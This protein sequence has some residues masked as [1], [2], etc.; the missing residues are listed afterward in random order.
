MHGGRACRRHAS[1]FQEKAP[2]CSDAPRCRA[3]L[4]PACAQRESPD[5][6]SCSSRAGDR[7]TRLHVVHRLGTSTTPGDRSDPVH[8]QWGLGRG[9][10]IA[11]E[12]SH[13]ATEPTPSLSRGKSSRSWSVQHVS[14]R[15]S[16]FLYLIHPTGR[17]AMPCM[18]ASAARF[19]TS[20]RDP[21]ESTG[22]SQVPHRPSP[23][24]PPTYPLVRRT[25]LPDQ[26]APW[27]Q[28]SAASTPFLRVFAPSIETPS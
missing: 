23:H 20:D 3:R 1:A 17:A 6:Q 10:S 19:R 18:Q 11:I 21:R 26:N 14:E 15:P 9:R 8:Q 27:V 16:N 12:A 22:A 28:P 7:S 24:H 4:E 25:S 2:S 13:S 5:R